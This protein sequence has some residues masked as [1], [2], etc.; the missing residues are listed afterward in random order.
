MAVSSPLIFKL[1]SAE[2]LT[3]GNRSNPCSLVSFLQKSLHGLH[4]PHFPFSQPN[5]YTRKA[6][7]QTKAGE[8]HLQKPRGSQLRSPPAARRPLWR[9]NSPACC[10]HHRWT[11]HGLPAL[12]ASHMHGYY[13]RSYGPT[14]TFLEVMGS[15]DSIQRIKESFEGTLLFGRLYPVWTLNGDDPTLLGVWDL[16]GIN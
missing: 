13:V 7:G 10:Q 9:R 8:C 11:S 1:I 14:H 2:E 3:G 5:C 12:W 15:L 16:S 4:D 6:G